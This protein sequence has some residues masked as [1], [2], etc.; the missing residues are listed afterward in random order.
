[1]RPR[2]GAIV[3]KALAAIG[4]AAL[5]A[6]SGMGSALAEKFPEKPITLIVPWAQGGGSDIAMRLV[7]DEATRHLG[8]SVVVVNKDGAGGAT[9]AREL[10]AA[11]PD[12]YTIGMVGS[13]EISRRYMHPDGDLISQLQPIALFGSEPLA[14]SARADTGYKS[15]ADFVKAAKANPGKIRNGN[16]APGG[17]SFIAI[18]VIEN[19]TGTKVT[20]VPYNG[21][22]PMVAA[23]LAGEV[24]TSTANVPDVIEH[25]KAGKVRLLGIS[26][27]K[28]YFLAPDV[29]TFKEQGFDMVMGI[30]RMIL[31]PKGIPADRL[32][33]LEAKLLETL[34]NGA[35]QERARK[36]GFN[37]TPMGIKESEAV[38][39]ADDKRLYPVLQEAGLVKVPKK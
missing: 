32:A 6:A 27:D 5:L 31:G 33:F 21:F 13:G 15:V 18:A 28:R 20:R 29:P 23:M 12:G 4:T 22:A 2:R 19:V 1:M 24:Q 3:V 9:G 37:V 26:S 25:H 7:A 34:K 36:A 38:L 30:W 16:D 35:F 17:V 10:I 11:K 14:L 8:V 39:V